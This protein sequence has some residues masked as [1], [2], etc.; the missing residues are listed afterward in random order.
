M[1]MTVYYMYTYIYNLI[2]FLI[3]KPAPIKPVELSEIEV[4][5]DHDEL[6]EFLNDENSDRELKEIIVG[7]ITIFFVVFVETYFLLFIQV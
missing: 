1:C 4:D 7:T 6:Q 3:V 2:Y 5:A